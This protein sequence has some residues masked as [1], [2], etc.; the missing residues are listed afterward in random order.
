MALAVTWEEGWAQRML[1]GV[2]TVLC[3]ALVGMLY[4]G[5]RIESIVNVRNFY[6][7]LRV[8]ETHEPA[9]AGTSRLLLHG[10]IKHGMQWFSD[11]YRREPTTYYA[12]DSGWGWRWGTAARGGRG[13]WG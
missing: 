7:S 1:W 11:E 13:G 5:Y 12:R 3:F 2:S 4:N 9:Q 8:K 6:G 10:S